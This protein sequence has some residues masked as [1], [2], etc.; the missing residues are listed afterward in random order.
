MVNKD[1]EAHMA[2]TSATV[3]G[4]KS[5][6]NSFLLKL[7]QLKGELFHHLV[8]KHLHDPTIKAHTPSLYLDQLL[9]TAHPILL[10]R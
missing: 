5:V 6:L 8:Q 3:Q 1:N 10:P 4:K 9:S 2:R 7:N